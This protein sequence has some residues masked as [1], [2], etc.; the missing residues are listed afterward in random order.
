MEAYFVVALDIELDL[1]ARQGPHPAAKSAIFVTNVINPLQELC[2]MNYAEAGVG[3]DR[4][5]TYL[6]NMATLLKIVSL[7]MW[8]FNHFP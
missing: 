5:Q 6:I 3:P 8:R 1:L 2:S 7:A 4:R